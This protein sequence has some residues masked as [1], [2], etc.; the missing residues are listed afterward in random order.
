LDETST[1]APL[2]NMDSDAAMWF[3]YV[4]GHFVGGNAGDAEV[5]ANADAFIEALENGEDVIF[6]S[7]IKIDPAGM[8]NA[9]TPMIVG[10]SITN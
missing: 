8:S 4:D 10:Q 5:V 2:I 9:K 1:E 6:T 7:D 3:W